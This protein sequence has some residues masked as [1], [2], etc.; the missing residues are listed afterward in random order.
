MARLPHQITTE[1]L[2]LRSWLG[3]DVPVIRDVVL[4]SLDHIKPWMDWAGLE[5]FPDDE[6]RLLIESWEQHR[7]AGNDAVYGIFLN[8][9]NGEQ[10]AAIG[11]TGVHR[12]IGPGGVEIGYWLAPDATGQG[13]ITES[14]RALTTMALAQPG[15][16]HVEIHHDP[17]N[18]ASAAVPRRLGFRLIANRPSPKTAPAH[19]GSQDIWQV[20]RQ[21]WV[22]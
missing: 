7:L 8:N 10:G 20:R 2:T 6:R 21:Q 19:T 5:P 18:V 15:I 11:G 4:R 3:D 13:Y 9:T 1:R 12:R 16:D 22:A 17:D 14:T